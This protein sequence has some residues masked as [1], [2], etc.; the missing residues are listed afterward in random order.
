MCTFGFAFQAGEVSKAIQ[1]GLREKR[2]DY[3]FKELGIEPA[4]NL[5]ESVNLDDGSDSRS[6]SASAEASSSRSRSQ[7]KERTQ[8]QSPK[9][10]AAPKSP[11]RS[12]GSPQKRPKAG[13]S[14]PGTPS[15]AKGNDEKKKKK[16]GEEE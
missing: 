4:H 13:P 14:K 11:A 12:G 15:K 7:S 10:R 3:N 2:S 6:R 9:K 8:G 16:S 1:D 5:V